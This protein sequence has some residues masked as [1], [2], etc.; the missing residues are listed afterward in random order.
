MGH[1]KIFQNFL[2]TRED[3]RLMHQIKP[4]ELNELL[5]KYIISVRQANGSEYEPFYHR[6]MIGRFE[7]NLKR[8]KY[9]TSLIK[10][11]EFNRLKEALKSKQKDLKKREGK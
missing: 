3:D 9:E 7:R 11:V 1:F 2:K 4:T 10:G 8:H 6:G 5:T